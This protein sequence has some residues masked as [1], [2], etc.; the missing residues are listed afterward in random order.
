MSED[1][2]TRVGVAVKHTR[3]SSVEIMGSN[4]IHG[5]KINDLT[6]TKVRGKILNMVIRCLKIESG[7]KKRRGFL[8]LE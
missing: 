1:Q 5:T 3:L 6:T 2:F 7:R 4:P 8:L